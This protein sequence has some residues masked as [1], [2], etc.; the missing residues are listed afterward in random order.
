MKVLFMDID[1]VLN[2]TRTA[3]ALHGYPRVYA[4]NGACWDQVAIQLLR[5]LCAKGGIKVVLSSSWRNDKDWDQIGPALGLPIIDRTPTIMGP[6]GAEIAAWLSDHPEVGNYAIVDDDSDMLPEQKLCFV[7]TS[8]HDGLTW[9]PFA[10]LCSIFGVSPYDCSTA[11]LT[12]A[13]PKALDWE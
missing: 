8:H 1:G 3:V 13:N 5:G 2:S 11:R 7:Q 12:K 4:L 6:R 10:K 9:E